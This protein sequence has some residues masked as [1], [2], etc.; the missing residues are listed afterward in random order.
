MGKSG[1]MWSKHKQVQPFAVEDRA[2]WAITTGKRPRNLRE[3][4]DQ[5]HMIHPKRIS[6]PFRVGPPRPQC[7]DPE[8]ETT[9]LLERLCPV[10]SALHVPGAPSIDPLSEKNRPLRGGLPAP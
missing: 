7:E 10:P 2:L 8:R 5:V 3:F 9:S 6:P 4:R 1:T